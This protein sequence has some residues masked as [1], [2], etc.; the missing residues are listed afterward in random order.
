[1][2]RPFAKRV[3]TGALAATMLMLSAAG[4]AFG[5]S[6][7]E[8]A[9]PSWELRVCAAP[10]TTPFSNQDEAGLENRIAELLAD[11][12]NAS[13]TYL[14]HAFNADLINRQF[15]EG[16]C[17]VLM[18]VSDGFEGGLN[19][20]SYYQSPYVH[21]YRADSGIEIESMDDP[22]LH[23]LTFAVQGVATPPHEA[24]LARGLTGNVKLVFGNEEGSDRL[25]RMIDA[26]ANG[27]VDVGFGWGPVVSYYAA[28]HEADLVVRP[29]EP[30]FDLPA[31]FQ[32]QPMTMAVRT[33]DYALQQRL[34]RAIAARWDDI[35]AVLEEFNVPVVPAP[36]PMV[37]PVP[38]DSRNL[39][40][41]VILPIPTG[42]RTYDAG[43]YNLIGDAARQ[44]ALMAESM[45]SRSQAS[46]ELDVTLLLSSSPSAAAAERAAAAMVALDEVDA[47]IGGVGS[48]QAEVIAGIAAGAGLPFINIGDPAIELREQCFPTT[49][50]IQASAVTY[51]QAMVDLYGVQDGPTNW[52]VVHEDDS[53]SQLMVA[54]LERFIGEA[55]DQLVGSRVVEKYRPV[56]HD[57][58]TE[59]EELGAHTL[60]VLLDPPD[61]LALIGQAE[62]AGYDLDM[63]PFPDPL[64]Q[65]R[66]FLAASKKY[67]AGMEVPRLQLWDPT[68]ESGRAAEINEQF[69]GQW[70]LPF[71]APAWAAFEAVTVLTAAARAADSTAAEPLTDAMYGV[72]AGALGGKEP[73][74]FFSDVN[75]E[76]SQELYLVEVNA[77]NEWGIRPSRQL[78]AGALL[79]IWSPGEAVH[80]YGCQ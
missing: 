56:Y 9:E 40:I 7:T 33:S 60:I 3:L 22:I 34:N 32:V 8:A 53:E 12:L 55:G 51:L 58:L 76:L 54:A 63:A 10:N 14:W 21:V 1:M 67:G 2:T 11:E 59:A 64:T 4:T 77:E 49:F 57:I 19:T 73:G 65:T 45:A 42:A 62:D 47:I 20:V 61:Q 78:G 25:G 75:R 48:G 26:V 37:S 69:V 41:G 80:D 18:G 66:E 44:G 46:G 50:H 6:S 38:D 5:Q 13:L 17:D 39:R 23:D 79:E 71:D 52:F 68:L 72:D 29:I 16:N 30:I 74:L 15:A 43:I 28:R 70:G 35:N 31:I 36:A 27:D 24:L